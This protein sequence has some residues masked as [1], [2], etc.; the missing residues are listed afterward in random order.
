MG[1]R[2]MALR[3][4]QES[5]PGA[6]LFLLTENPLKPNQQ[7]CSSL[8]SGFFFPSLP[9]VCEMGVNGSAI[10]FLCLFIPTLLCDVNSEMTEKAQKEKKNGKRTQRGNNSYYDSNAFSLSILFTIV[11]VDID[12]YP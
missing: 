9:K 10:V 5:G 2:S 12:A 8:V 1:C 3:T 7:V 4:G 6:A 11:P